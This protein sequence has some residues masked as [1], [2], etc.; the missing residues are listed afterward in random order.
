[1]ATSSGVVSENLRMIAAL[2]PSSDDKNEAGGSEFRPRE[3]SDESGDSSG[4]DKLVS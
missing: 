2:M 3:G 1:M 4:G